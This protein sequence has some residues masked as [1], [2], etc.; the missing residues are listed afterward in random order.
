VATAIP[1]RPA[2]GA[3]VALDADD[4]RVR[5]RRAL[6]A[7]MVGG[8][9]ALGDLV[10]SGCDDG[11]LYAFSARTGATVWRHHVGLPFGTAP[12][13]YRVN[14]VQYVAIAA[15]GSSVTSVTG[16]RPGARLVVLRLPR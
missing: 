7:P 14:G 9:L 2:R 15:G 5:W 10:L 13:T 12:L 4:G 8:A 16:A 1:G 6:P 11:Y 3:L